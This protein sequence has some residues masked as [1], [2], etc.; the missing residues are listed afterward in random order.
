MRIHKSRACVAGVVGVAAVLGCLLFGQ[1]GLSQDESGPGNA[2]PKWP[3]DARLL[4][5]FWSG[6]L[7][8]G[9]SV[10][11]VRDAQTGVATAKLLFPVEEIVSVCRSVHWRSSGAEIFQSGRDYI[12]HPGSNEITLPK[13]SRIPAFTEQDLRRPAGSQAYQLT[14]RDGHGEI[15]FGATDEYHQMQVSVSYRHSRDA[16]PSAL[17]AF[18]QRALPRTIRRLQNRERVSLV[19]LGDSISTGCN[20]SGW[21]KV[22]PYQPPYQDLLVQHLRATYSPDIQL[23]NLAVGGTSTPWGI[24]QVPEVL[25]AKPDL[26][27]LAFGMNDSAGRSAEEYQSNIVAMM[28]AIREGAPDTEFILVATM[29]GNRDWTTLKPE[30]FPQYRDA[31]A[32][33]VRPGVAL[34]DMTSIWTEV[35]NRKRDWDLTGNGVNHPNDF[36]HRIYAQVLTSLLVESKATETEVSRRSDVVDLVKQDIL[37]PMTVP[38]WPDKAPNGDGSFESSAAK[39]TVHL[40]KNPGG[41]AVVICPGG[42]YGGLVTGGEGHEIARWLNRHGIAGIVLEYRL[43]AGRSFVPLLDAQRAIRIVRAN[44]DAWRINSRQVGIM[45]FSAGGHLASTAATH[46]DEG[47]A[48]ANDLLERTSCRPDFAVLV[49]PVVTMGE[50]TH[51]GSR[52]NLLGADPS[53]EMIELFS[54]EKQ[55]SEKTPPMFLAHAVDDEPVP[56]INSQQLFD[57]LKSAKIPARYLELPSGGHGLNGYQGPMWDAWQKQSLEWLAEQNLIEVRLQEK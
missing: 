17:P 52:V 42:G 49:Y 21:A 3:Y 46:F 48:A 15:L 34:A 5:P 2:E 9:E 30:L 19:L 45:G 57:A 25:A 56:C 44:A 35:L 51:G 55:V 40:P 23:T 53:P 18:D 1:T 14:H 54:N 38:L 31:L 50:S 22:P 32:K 24:S 41:S 43:P 28:E 10:L 11:F 6:N 37:E 13:D 27:M 20:A 29:L 16:W 4:Q 39:M 26:V 33:L 36:G 7:V 12:C 8:E 47:N